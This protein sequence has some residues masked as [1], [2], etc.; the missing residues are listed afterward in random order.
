M[1]AEFMGF[2]KKLLSSIFGSRSLVAKVVRSQDAARIM[3]ALIN[4]DEISSIELSIELGMN[5]NFSCGQGLLLHERSIHSKMVT[6][7]HRITGQGLAAGFQC[8]MCGFSPNLGEEYLEQRFNEGELGHP[9][10]RHPGT[11]KAR[12]RIAKLKT[13]PVSSKHWMDNVG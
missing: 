13:Q 6:D 7:A 10:P 4:S 1:E 5:D 8:N 3:D 2:I 11:E 12:E 9:I